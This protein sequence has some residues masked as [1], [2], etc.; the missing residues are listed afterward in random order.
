MC[1]LQA[2]VTGLRQ[3]VQAFQGS[4][5]GVT[6]QDVLELMLV[7][8]YY[9]MLKEV[10]HEPAVCSLEAAIARLQHQHR[11]RHTCRTLSAPM[12]CRACWWQHDCVSTQLPLHNMPPVSM[13]AHALDS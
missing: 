10:R 2:I 11:T 4:V 12:I 9:D 1:C 5:T 6:P 13:H 7:T 3:S 8:Q